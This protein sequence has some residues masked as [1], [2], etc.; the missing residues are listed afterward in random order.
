VG[1]LKDRVAIGFPTHSRASLSLLTTA[2]GDASQAPE[3]SQFIY[4]FS[5]GLVVC[6]ALACAFIGSRSFSKSCAQSKTEKAAQEERFNS[7]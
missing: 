2:S 1:G 6:L 4:V 7:I 5:M 3:W